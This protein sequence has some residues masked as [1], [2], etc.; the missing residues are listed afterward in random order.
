LPGRPGGGFSGLRSGGPTFVTTTGSTD[1][2]D[3]KVVVVV[4][5][6]A[7]GAAMV[8]ES[9]SGAIVGTT[10]AVTAVGGVTVVGAVTAVDS[11]AAAVGL[12][13]S[14]A[15]AS[16]TAGELTTTCTAVL[17]TGR[18]SAWAS[19][20]AI[21]PNTAAVTAAVPLATR[22]ELFFMGNYLLPSWAK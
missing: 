9:G 17:T 14:N 3:A 16:A 7:T 4:P 15:S 13:G 21:T 5:A 11:D 12:N 8:A 1:S 22:R 6:A 2:V 10:G 18:V 19:V 20:P